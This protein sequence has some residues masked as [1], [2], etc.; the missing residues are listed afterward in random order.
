[1]GN[2]EWFIEKWYTQEVK[3]WRVKYNPYDALALCLVANRKDK[4]LMGW[5]LDW[6]RKVKH[7]MEA[8]INSKSTDEERKKRLKGSVY[9]IMQG[10]AHLLCNT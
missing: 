8:L 9:Q 2:Y 3:S 7:E 1:M 6:Y 10:Y 4:K 5:S